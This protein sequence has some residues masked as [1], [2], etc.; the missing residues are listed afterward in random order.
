MEPNLIAMHP[1]VA[2]YNGSHNVQHH[3]E[4]FG[5]LGRLESKEKSGPRASEIPNRCNGNA[6][7]LGDLSTFRIL[8]TVR[9]LWGALQ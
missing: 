3:N 7:G 5:L 4:S 9:S 1:N 8:A 2:G 6:G